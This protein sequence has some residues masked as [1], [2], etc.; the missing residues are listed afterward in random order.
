LALYL[1]GVPSDLLNESKLGNDLIPLQV[2]KAQ[3]DKDDAICALYKVMMATLKTAS[4]EDIL[5]RREEFGDHFKNMI[6]LS[7]KCSLFIAGYT[8]GRY[9]RKPTL[10]NIVTALTFILPFRTDGCI[11]SVTQNL[12]IQRVISGVR[13][14]AYHVYGKKNGE[15]RPGNP[16]KS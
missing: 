6:N 15:N 3:R 1:I 8:S 4:E 5:K 2:I 7:I 9:Y 12:T 16:R 13:K 11:G 14:R 10:V